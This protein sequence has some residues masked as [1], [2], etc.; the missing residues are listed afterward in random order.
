M[1]VH[2]A[3][4]RVEH[5]LREAGVHSDEILTRKGLEMAYSCGLAQ[6]IEVSSG[7][8][9]GDPIIRWPDT[10]YPFMLVLVMYMKCFAGREPVEVYWERYNLRWKIGHGE[11]KALDAAA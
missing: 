3:R 5:A 4:E 2:D 7:L 6:Q 1:N 11:M 10:C 8:R 9:S